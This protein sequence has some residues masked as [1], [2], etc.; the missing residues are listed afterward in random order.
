MLPEPTTNR[1]A[2]QACY[3]YVQSDRSA[4]KL[5]L[6]VALRKASIGHTELVHHW[7]NLPHVS[8]YWQQAW[9]VEKIR[10]Y[11]K[12]QIASYH[13]VFIVF[14]ND[15]PVAYTEF[16]PVAED[17]LA[18]HCSHQPH[19][20][21]WHILIGPTDFIGCGLSPAIGHA[22]LQYLFHHKHASQV[23]CEPDSRN[24]RMINFVR[25]LQHKDRGLIQLGEKLARLMVC[26]RKDF[27]S[28]VLPT[29][30][31]KTTQEA[32]A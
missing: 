29:L 19:D 26:E 7:M 3:D 25:R 13:E 18:M 20:W 24:L 16:Y 23:F 8:E 12:Q 4:Q 15:R 1:Y 32:L 21:G 14:V 30:S 22:V 5:P 27:N 28:L 17:N 6:V 9:S 10:D 31:Y 11:L 2:F